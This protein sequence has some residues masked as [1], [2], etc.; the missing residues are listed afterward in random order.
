[1]EEFLKELADSYQQEPEQNTD[2]IRDEAIATTLMY[3]PQACNFVEEHTE[4]WEEGH[5]LWA[6]VLARAPKPG[7]SME[8][9]LG[10]FIAWEAAA[11]VVAA[12]FMYRGYLAGL[13]EG[14]AKAGTVTFVVKGEET[15]G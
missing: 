11:R 9:W 4:L 5:A 14:K 3:G 12:I 13:E 8:Q 6:N 15:G 2:V 1:M 7:Q 10:K